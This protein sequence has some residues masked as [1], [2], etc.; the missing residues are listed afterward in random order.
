MD[1]KG[2]TS[3]DE[4][5]MSGDKLETSGTAKE[6]ESLKS[7]EEDQEEVD[8]DALK[9]WQVCMHYRLQPKDQRG[10]FY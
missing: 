2:E 10:S 9:T 7:T 4:L 8:P 6:M 5:E 3:A 1:L